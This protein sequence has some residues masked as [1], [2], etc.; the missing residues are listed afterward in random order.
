MAM[1]PLQVLMTKHTSMLEQMHGGSAHATQQIN[2]SAAASI[3][4][5]FIVSGIAVLSSRLH[6]TTILHH[7]AI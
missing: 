1:A 7:P 6:R 4:A 5:C 3:K 2:L